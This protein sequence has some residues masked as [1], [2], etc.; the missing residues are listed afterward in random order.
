MK[1]LLVLTDF[2]ANA[3]HAEAVAVRL[4][5]KLKAD[6]TLYHT[7][8]YIPFALSNSQGPLITESMDILF[9]DS[10]EQ[11]KKEAGHLGAIGA[12]LGYQTRIECKNGDGNL[13]ENIRD[14]TFREDI[15]MVI[16]GGRSGGTLEHLLTGSDTAAVINKAAKPVW[17]IPLSEDR[18]LPEK[19]VFATNF[20]TADIPAVDF[21]LDLAK[22]LDFQLEIIHVVRPGEVVTEIGP[23]VAFRKFLAHRGL[24]CKQVF[25]E[26]LQTTLQH[27][28]TANK[29][30]VIAMTHQHHSFVSKLFVRSES[31]AAITQKQLAVLV[32][33]PDFK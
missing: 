20:G 26:G 10:A 19:V 22:G 21:L 25:G 9:K 2:S 27:Y 32:F 3:V 28:C 8:P 17:V 12:K 6:M 4:A 23:E 31:T 13:A 30:D 11:L 29:V 18:G 33:P 16:M 24:N 1:K 5:A 7:L 14:L 15:D